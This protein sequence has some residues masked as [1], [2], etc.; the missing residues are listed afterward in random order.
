MEENQELI[1]SNNILPTQQYLQECFDYNEEVG[2]LLWK[3]RPLHH[4]DSVDRYLKWNNSHPGKIAY[5]IRK[6]RK[7][8]ETYIEGIDY[9]TRKIIWKLIYGED[10]DR[11]ININKDVLDNRIINLSKPLIEEKKESKD[12]KK[13]ELPTQEY[14]LECFRYDLVT[15]LLYWKERPLHHFD[16]NKRIMKSFNSRFKNKLVG[17]ISK[18]G[19]LKTGIGDIKFY[20]HRIIWKLIYGTD[21]VNIIDHI[22]GNKLDNRIENLREATKSE[23]NRN[24][25]ILDKYNKSGHRG[26]YFDKVRLKRVAQITVNNKTIFLGRFNSIEEAIEAR[27]EANEKYFGDFIGLS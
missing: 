3:H 15:G 7:T 23:N 11:I 5:K 14:L 21:P 13:R 1:K 8:V 16:G 4:F 22:N 10:V 17:V 26:V 24:R 25:N 18:E 12:L 2:Q 19:Y 6:N 9:L 20:N 27:G